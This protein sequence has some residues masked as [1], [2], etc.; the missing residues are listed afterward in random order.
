MA[1]KRKDFTGVLSGE[2]NVPAVELIREC[3]TVIDDVFNQNFIKA[4]E[5][6]YF[7]KANPPYKEIAKCCGFSEDVFRDSIRIK[8][9]KVVKHYKKSQVKISIQKP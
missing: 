5:I 9:E 2:H 1:N 4:F 6:L 3:L 8:L 7:D